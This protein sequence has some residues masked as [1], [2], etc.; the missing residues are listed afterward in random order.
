M[1]TMEFLQGNGFRRDQGKNVPTTQTRA[2][3]RRSNVRDAYSGRTTDVPRAFRTGIYQ[4]NASDAHIGNLHPASAGLEFSSANHYNPTSHRVL[5]TAWETADEIDRSGDVLDECE[6]DCLLNAAFATQKRYYRASGGE[7][8]DIQQR[9]FRRLTRMAEGRSLPAFQLGISDSELEAMA[10]PLPL[11][12][13][14]ACRTID[15]RML[16]RS[17]TRTSNKKSV[18]AKERKCSDLSEAILKART[19]TA[20]KRLLIVGGIGKET[21]RERIAEA[22]AC[23]VEWIDAT[24]RNNYQSLRTAAS[25]SHLL[26]SL[27]K[28]VGHLHTDCLGAFSRETGIP[29]V[30]VPRG[31]NPVAIAEAINQ[32]VLQIA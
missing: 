4:L 7:Y 3:E 12:L 19:A 26:V 1:P 20:G 9:L 27:I 18:K 13:D 16:V 32:Q 30:R 14:M 10:S 24:D 31:F 8:D 15:E 25:R 2:G 11:L 28:V 17:T 5:A 6:I 22:L 29:F 23:T 21:D